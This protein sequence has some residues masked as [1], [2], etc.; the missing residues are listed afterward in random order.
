MEGSSVGFEAY[1]G[2]LEIV[3]ATAAWLFHALSQLKEY[4]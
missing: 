3:R 1:S 4:L 2:T